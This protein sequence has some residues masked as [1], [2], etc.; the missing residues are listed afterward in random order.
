MIPRGFVLVA[1]AVAQGLFAVS[2]AVPDSAG[3]AAALVGNALSDVSCP[4]AQLCVAV[5]AVGNVLTST[6]PTGTAAWKPAT[7]DPGRAI[8]AVACPTAGLCV[9]T[10]DGA[11]VL[12]S[13]APTAGARAWRR[14]PLEGDV[15][16]S[17]LGTDVSCPSARL[18]V[19]VDADGNIFSTSD[20]GGGGRTWRRASSGWG[21]A[22][23]AV[24]CPSERL[25]VAV[26][27]NGLVATSNDPRAGGGTW[28]A[29]RVGK[30]SLT[31][32]SC[33]TES[34]CVVAE[35][36]ETCGPPAAGCR[37]GGDV[38]S[39]TNPTGSASAWAVTARGV[40]LATVDCPSS[41]LCV[42]TT[43]DGE[44]VTSADPTGDPTAWTITHVRSSGPLDGVS[45]ASPSLCVVAGDLGEAFVSTDPT[46]GVAAWPRRVVDVVHSNRFSFYR[47]T[48]RPDGSVELTVLFPYDGFLA[49]GS[50]RQIV[51]V[52]RAVTASNA[53]LLLRPTAAMRRALVGARAIRLRVAVTYTPSGGRPRT[54]VTRVTF[55][56]S[57]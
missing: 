34:L 31:G 1:A 32:A 43:V 16:L 13:T 12:W 37:S 39:S 28:A 51:P 57:R 44:V 5:D 21:D 7:V 4:A 40:G 10:D 3:A 18:C 15:G 19:A 42:G 55:R 53:T 29:T 26:G 35:Q 52:R 45:C 11:F 49:A 27:L 38:V 41:S 54:M 30:S 33:A 8:A 36:T 47:A 46:G 17:S 2:F 56:R 14:A 6:D 48:N 9:A 20:P 25:C 50:A 22:F 23:N 24:T